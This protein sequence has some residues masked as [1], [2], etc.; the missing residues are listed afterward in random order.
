MTAS[1][2]QQLLLSGGRG[3]NFSW[4]VKRGE[5]GEEEEGGGKKELPTT[6]RPFRGSKHTVI[7]CFQKEER[8]RRRGWRR[9]EG[10]SFLPGQDR[11]RS[12]TQD[13]K[14]KRGEREREDRLVSLSTAGTLRGSMKWEGGAQCVLRERIAS[15][16]LPFP[17]VPL[18]LRAWRRGEKV[19]GR[20]GMQV[21]LFCKKRST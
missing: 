10:E 18:P 6:Y 17:S 5:G 3:Y 13:G 9:V 8:E 2:E 4:K 16:R 15:T 11:F 7:T 14:W 1:K 12:D 19:E 20:R 21:D